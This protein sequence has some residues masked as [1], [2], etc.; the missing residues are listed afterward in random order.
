APARTAP[1]G[2]LAALVAA[3]LVGILIGEMHAGTLG[4]MGPI[5]VGLLVLL[6]GFAGVEHGRRIAAPVLTL[7]AALLRRLVGALRE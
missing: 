7:D 1:G 4:D 2:G 6:A 5:A 3:L